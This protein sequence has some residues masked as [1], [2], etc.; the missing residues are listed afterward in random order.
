M[1]VNIK[2]EAAFIGCLLANPHLVEV[3]MTAG[4]SENTLTFQL[5]ID[6]WKWIEQNYSDGV[7]VTL[8]DA[9]FRFPNDR[10][11]ILHCAEEYVTAAVFDRMVKCLRAMEA[12]RLFRDSAMRMLESIDADGLPPDIQAISAEL[13]DTDKRMVEIAQNDRIQTLADMMPQVR[14]KYAKPSTRLR[15]FP[16]TWE[17]NMAFSFHQGEIMSLNAASGTGKT[18]MGVQMAT[19]LAKQ[20]R[21][22]LY[23]CT[24]STDVEILERLTAS[25]T[26]IPHYWAMDDSSM[27][28]RSLFVGKMD[29]YAKAFSECITVVGLRHRKPNAYDVVRAMK[30]IE[31]Q[32]GHIDCVFIDFIQD[33]AF[34]DSMKADSKVEKIEKTV[35]IIHD[36]CLANGNACIF[37]GQ[38]NRTGERDERPGFE[39]I[40]SCSAIAE[41]AHIVCFLHRKPKPADPGIRKGRQVFV[42]QDGSD[43]Q[44]QDDGESDITNFYS[45][46]TRNTTPFD[47]NLTWSRTHYLSRISAPVTYRRSDWRVVDNS[48]K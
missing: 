12:G 36:A 37:M 44:R 27:E 46:K 35:D 34:P 21:R 10:T 45:I 4:V 19:E 15:L 42:L 33:M 47:I 25:H 2:Q 9:L 29:E 31:Y 38:L 22:V 43:A 6:V 30:N 24:E 8:D 39:Q 41:K 32:K 11:D 28:R 3:A 5:Y 48:G 18:A 20:G 13:A 7:S 14:E 23:V 17:A 16:E 26:E 40:K 1:L